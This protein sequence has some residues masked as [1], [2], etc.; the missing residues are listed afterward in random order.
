MNI[1]YINLANKTTA[2]TDESGK[3]RIINDEVMG[4]ELVAENKL[5][6]LNKRIKETQAKVENYKE[7]KSLSKFMI[8]TQPIIAV[9]GVTI[10]GIVGGA[11]GGLTYLIGALSVCAPTAAVFGIAYPVS[12]KRLAG[13]KNQLKR[14][15]ELKKEAIQT[16]NRENQPIRTKEIRR[17]EPISLNKANEIELPLVIK[18]L[19]DAFEDAQT[20]PKKLV[21]EKK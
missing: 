17:N 18:Q 10:A 4:E 3:I 7:L 21:R 2:V 16:I 12:K 11:Y 9:A 13:Y 5:D 20:K 15:E 1:E 14:A 8:V 6:I 19:D